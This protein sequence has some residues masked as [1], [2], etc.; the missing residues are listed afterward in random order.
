[1]NEAPWRRMV[2]WGDGGV[3]RWLGQSLISS[4]LGVDTGWSSARRTQQVCEPHHGMIRA[5][6]LHGT[7]SNGL[8]G[9][10]L[11]FRELLRCGN[12]TFLLSTSVY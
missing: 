1:M 11:P 2:G 8:N 5:L 9:K 12:R 3:N 10:H 4:L 6:G 7:V